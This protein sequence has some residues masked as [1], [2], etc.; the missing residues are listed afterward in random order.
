[1][2][3]KLFE[4]VE[5]NQFKLNPV[6]EGDWPIGNDPVQLV[7][8][9]YKIVTRA[10][11]SNEIDINFYKGELNKIKEIVNRLSISI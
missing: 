2:K 11:N 10:V 8:A 1:M 4:N 7:K 6:N 9:L 5:G 3:E